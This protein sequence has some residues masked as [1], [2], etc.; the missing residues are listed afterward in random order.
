MT[1]GDFTQ[2][3]NPDIPAFLNS[4][5]HAFNGL[6]YLIIQHA[7]DLP[8]T[9]NKESSVNFEFVHGHVGGADFNPGDVVDILNASG[10]LIGQLQTDANGYFQATPLF[11]KVEVEDGV[12][13]GILEEGEKISFRY[14]GQIIESD[15][16]FNGNFSGVELNLDFTDNSSTP[17]REMTINV[18]PNPA[19]DFSTIVIELPETANVSIE[20]LDATG[21]VV[22]QLLPQ[23]LL[24]AGTTTV[25]WTNMNTLP[26]GMYHV[27]ILRDGRILPN[28]TQ[29]VVKR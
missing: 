11:G 10:E 12:V 25:E 20:A 1:G 13:D 24:T 14:Q 9:S 8:R 4:M 23:Q 7:P 5:T 3:F 27:V 26:A 15:H 2:S 21:R 6:G 28:L 19:D 18:M 16:R 22:K 17:E 29:R